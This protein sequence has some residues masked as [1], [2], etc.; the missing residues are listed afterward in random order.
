MVDRAAAERGD[1]RLAVLAASLL[2]R[3]DV[4][5]GRMFSTVGLR[6][7]GKVFGLVDNDGELMV[8]VPEALADERVGRGEVARVVM[9]GRPMREWVTMPYDAGEAAWSTLLGEAHAYLEEIT[10]R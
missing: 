2:E 4:D 3:D 10:P 1:A 7:R 8:K 5:W 9:Q 6:V